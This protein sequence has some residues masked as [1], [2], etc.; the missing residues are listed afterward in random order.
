MRELDLLVVGDYLSV[1]EFPFVYVSTAAYR[2]TIAALSD[3][4]E[5]DPVACVTPGH[6][7]ALSGQEALAIAREDL[8]YL[9]ALKSAV[10]SALAGRSDA[11]RGGRR[12]RGGERSARR[13]G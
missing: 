7:R 2:A 10:R 1:I 5:R 12:G 6:G 3:A 4:L 8:A 11:R 13:G 9:H